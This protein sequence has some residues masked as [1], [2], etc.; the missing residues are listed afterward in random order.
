MTVARMTGTLKEARNCMLSLYKLKWLSVIWSLKVKEV[1]TCCS[2]FSYFSYS[3]S[4]FSSASSSPF[5][6]F[7]LGILLIPLLLTVCA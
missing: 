6:L 7:L 3:K 4:L 2:Y 1:Y 5:L